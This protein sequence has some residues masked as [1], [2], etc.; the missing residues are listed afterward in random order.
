MGSRTD[1]RPKLF[2][3]Q[4]VP[5]DQIVALVKGADESNMAWVSR[6]SLADAVEY[7]RPVADA[8]GSNGE[9]DL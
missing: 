7:V 2:R 1:L 6:D 4:F 3:R 8:D 5:R 9:S